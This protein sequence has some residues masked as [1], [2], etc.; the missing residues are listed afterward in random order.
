MELLGKGWL[1]VPNYIMWRKNALMKNAQVS[2]TPNVISLSVARYTSNTY[3]NSTTYTN[4]S[5]IRVTVYGT[6]D[7]TCVYDSNT[8]TQ[9][10]SN[11]ST[12]FTFGKY[13]GVDDGTATSGTMTLS[14]NGITSF[15]GGAFNTAK[16]ATDYCGCITSVDNWGSVTIIGTGCF[17]HNSMTNYTVPSFI[18]L[19]KPVAFGACAN[20]TT[21]IISNSVVSILESGDILPIFLSGTTS[22]TSLT[23]VYVGSGVLTIYSQAL[24][25]T[26]SGTLNYHFYSDTPPSLTSTNAFNTTNLGTIYV[27]S[28]SLSAYQSATNWS[29]YASYMVGE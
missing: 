6:G 14:G 16:A 13:M 28:A 29:D 27:P 2:V 10:C 8:V 23:N 9:T 11:G 3:A 19:I 7:I 4:D 15:G 20:L 21:L 25:A 12:K 22:C 24:Y 26:T 1:E 17:A 18:T 5:F